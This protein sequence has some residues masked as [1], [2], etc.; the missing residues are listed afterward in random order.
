LVG[1]TSVGDGL[2]LHPSKVLLARQEFAGALDLIATSQDIIKVGRSP[3]LFLCLKL[4]H[5][6]E[7]K[8]FDKNDRLNQKNQQAALHSSLL[9]YTPLLIN[10]DQL[11]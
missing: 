5:Q 10:M 8:Y 7:S 6:K 11:K 9:K 3:Q 4:G 1:D 2:T